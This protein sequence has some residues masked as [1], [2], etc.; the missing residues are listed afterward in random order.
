MSYSNNVQGLLLLLR[1]V[2]FVFIPYTSAA[3]PRTSNA[4]SNL[5][6]QNLA[7]PTLTLPNQI[8]PSPNSSLTISPP[9]VAIQIDAMHDIYF[10][11]FRQLLPE[12]IY[13]GAIISIQTSLMVDYFERGEETLETGSVSFDAYGAQ[14]VFDN[15]TGRLTYAMAHRMFG[16]LG[17]FL[18]ECD[19]S[20]ARFEVWEGHGAMARLLSAGAL[21]ADEAG[22]STV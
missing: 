14:I 4:I 22:K 19:M 11:Q 9:R 7:L 2:F 6:L 1:T 8:L 15:P 3:V 18:M 17:E 10:T 21:M 12:R 16:E 5:T 13:F 20:T